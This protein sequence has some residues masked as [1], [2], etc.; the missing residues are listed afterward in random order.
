MRPGAISLGMLGGL[1][2]LV[3]SL[4]SPV[5][6]FW[7]ASSALLYPPCALHIRF[8]FSLLSTRPSSRRRLFPLFALLTLS[9]YY[10]FRDR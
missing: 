2:A 9:L 10:F 1:A 7:C 6:P 8:L 4:F 5:A 3:F